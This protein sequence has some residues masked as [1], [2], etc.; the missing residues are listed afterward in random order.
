MRQ[1]KG[2]KR[3]CCRPEPQ[4]RLILERTRIK[5]NFRTLKNQPKYDDKNKLSRS[6][7]TGARATRSFSFSKS[8]SSRP[9][10]AKTEVDLNQVLRF[11]TVRDEGAFSARTR[12]SRIMASSVPLLSIVP[13]VSSER[14]HT[15]FLDLHL[16]L[17]LQSSPR[18]SLIAFGQMP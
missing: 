6:V 5:S 12:L 9:R 8:C 4:E 10:S 1:P 13:T 18:G 2:L 7:S 16:D 3:K 11:L 17:S 14:P 15:I